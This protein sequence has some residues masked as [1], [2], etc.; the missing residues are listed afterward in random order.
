MKWFKRKHKHK[1]EQAFICGQIQDVKI[2]FIGTYCL[3]C[4][5]GYKELLD[6]VNNIETIYATYSEKYFDKDS[7]KDL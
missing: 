6:T 3:T 7:Q 1:W 5:K 4:R 2:K